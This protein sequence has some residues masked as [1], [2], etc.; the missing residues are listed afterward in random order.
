MRPVIVA[1]LALLAG[2]A[3]SVG[4]SGHL[5]PL[6]DAGDGG[7]GGTTGGECGTLSVNVDPLTMDFGRVV[8]HSTVTRTLVITNTSS[9]PITL[10]PLLLAG[11]SASL[12]TVTIPQ[13]GPEN[14]NYGEPIPPNG[15]V[16]FQV[17]FSPTQPST[18]DELAYVTVAYAAAAYLNVG[19]RG[20]GVSSGL[21]VTPMTNLISF[22]DVAPGQ[23]VTKLITIEDCANEPITVSASLDNSD[24]FTIGPCPAMANCP[25]LLPDGGGIT[26]NPGDQLTYPIVFTP[27]QAQDYVGYFIIQ[28]AFDGFVNIQ[29]SGAGWVPDA[30]YTDAGS[31]DG[32]AIPDAGGSDA[33][34]VDGGAVPDAGGDDGGVAADASYFGTSVTL[35][36]TSQT[37]N[38]ETGDFNDDGIDDL[39]QGTEGGVVIYLQQSDG[40]FLPNPIPLPDGGSGLTHAMPADLDGD[41]WMDFVATN[42]ESNTI[43]IEMNQHDGGFAVTELTISSSYTYQT[44]I[45]DFDG[46]G[47]PDL[48]VCG[49][50]EFVFFDDGGATSYR[51]PIQLETPSDLP[52]AGSTRTCYDLVVGDLNDD[53][54]A[55]IVA[56]I[57][58]PYLVTYLAIG[59][60]GFSAASLP[61]SCNGNV[62]GQLAIA[63]LDGDGLADLVCGS[64][65]GITV[66]FGIVAGE[67]GPEVYFD[68]GRG[69]LAKE[70]YLNQIVVAD[71]DGDGK[72]DVATAGSYVPYCYDA[73][74]ATFVFH[75]QGAGQFE[76][77]MLWTSWT[78]LSNSIAAFRTPGAS[79]ESLAVGQYCGTNVSVFPNLAADGGA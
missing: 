47:R 29:L 26:L 31:V 40:G 56:L 30:G 75:N 25:Q 36:S 57:Q 21:C 78:Q 67:I 15:A 77:S 4:S 61:T 10:Q 23:S 55:D 62:D 17:S 76:S 2:A 58:G 68:G 66:R 45:G 3:C 11:N 79:L 1:L 59:D 63:D 65:D 69:P 41:G 6:A 35:G 72:L 9:C 34:P 43:D 19:L 60:G 20:L 54:I 24:A 50:G 22:G 27:P 74:T 8:V 44:R 33:G 16:S 7:T 64:P 52:D 18:A 73:G 71:F 5:S 48:V 32:G 51:D 49:Q 13:G 28:D 42:G 12:F 70:Y 14:W 37:V 38:L 46:D 39:I 53:G